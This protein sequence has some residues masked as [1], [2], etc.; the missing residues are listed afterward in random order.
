MMANTVL[1]STIR[2]WVVR[3][4]WT[5]QLAVAHEQTSPQ[6]RRRGDL[7]CSTTGLDAGRARTD[8]GDVAFRVRRTLPLHDGDLTR[9]LRHR[10]ADQLR[11]KPTRK[12]LGRLQGH[13]QSVTDP[14]WDSAAR[15]ADA[16]GP[17]LRVA[18]LRGP[19]VG[20]VAG[21]RPQRRSAGER[22]PLA[23]E[24]I[25]EI[26]NCTTPSRRCTAP[27]AFTETTPIASTRAPPTTAAITIPDRNATMIRPPASNWSGLRLPTQAFANSDEEGATNPQMKTSAPVTPTDPETATTSIRRSAM[28]TACLSSRPRSPRP[29]IPASR[30][31]ASA[32]PH[33]RPS[34]RRIRARASRYG[35][36]SISRRCARSTR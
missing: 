8:G 29:R 16:S 6:P 22:R 21:L 25:S 12:G 32:S 17:P 20:G 14:T 2:A 23:A 28:T 35:R 31:S 1:V 4:S 7:R 36:S 13:A 30:T 33:Y 5:R 3:G 27:T 19:E 9:E 18:H 26:P 24:R 11:G 34:G 15:A 10:R